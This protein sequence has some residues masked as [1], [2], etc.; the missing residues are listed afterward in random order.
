VAHLTLRTTTLLALLLLSVSPAAAERRGVIRIG[1]APLDLAAGADTP[2]LGEPVGDAVGAYNAAADAYNAA[3]G[4]AP[5]SPMATGAIDR[6]DLGVRATLATVALGLETGH[7]NAFF[8]IE[9]AVG[10]ADRLRSYGVGIYPINLAGKLRRGGALVLYV[11]GGGTAGVLDRPAIDGELGALL[12]ARAAVGAR[13]RRLAVEVGY[14]GFVL[15][16]LVDRARIR[17]MEDYDPSGDAPPP[18]PAE[19][20]AGGEQ[21]GLVDLSVGLAF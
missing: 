11:S 8:R 15:G 1:V 13:Y 21:R 7:P 14:A 17:S 10:L 3:H 18:S 2:L 6:G 4:F 12:A 5:G 20:I 19:A 16:G 9:A